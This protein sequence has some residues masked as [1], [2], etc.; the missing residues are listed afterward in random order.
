[1]LSLLWKLDKMIQWKEGYFPPWFC[2]FLFQG[3]MDRQ[4]TVNLSLRHPHPA[5]PLQNSKYLMIRNYFFVIWVSFA[6]P[7]S[8]WECSFIIISEASLELQKFVPPYVRRGKRVFSARN[9][10]R[11]LTFSVHNSL[12]LFTIFVLH[13]IFL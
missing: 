13:T 5:L 3:N 11:R 10:Y 12:F 8:F 1:M 2:R 6:F 9:Q 4:W 7:K